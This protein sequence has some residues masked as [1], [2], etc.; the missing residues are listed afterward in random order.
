MKRYLF[1]CAALCAA[2]LLPFALWFGYVLS[3]FDPMGGSIAATIRH[4][5]DLIQQT[6]GPR[7]IFVGGSSSPYGT[8][9]QMAADQLGVSVINVGATAYLGLDFYLNYIEVYARPGDIVVF[10]PE[11]SMMTR[12]NT[13]YSLVWMGA[14]RNLAVWRAVPLSYYPGVF[15]TVNDYYRL[16]KE[17]TTPEGLANG[18]GGYNEAFGPLGDVTAQR[19]SILESGYNTQD[20]FEMTPEAVSMENVNKINRTAQRLQKKG[21]TFLYAFAPY[22]AQAVSSTPEQ[23][24]AY[25]RKIGQSLNMPVI[26][27]L[28]QAAFAGEYMYDSNN[29][30]TTEGAVINT[31]NLIDGV[32]PYL[33][34]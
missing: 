16:K 25:G 2:I 8:N 21:V 6:E 19:V 34:R 12:D 14:G 31:Q 1:K 17:N 28:E 26:V 23:W 32:K 11:Y 33:N 4:K 22:A 5:T 27:S 13:D 10:A 29:H 24:E 3:L 15:S 30:L 18:E 20:L 7:V 9:C